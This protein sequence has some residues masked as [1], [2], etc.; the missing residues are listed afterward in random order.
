MIAAL[1]AFALLGGMTSFMGWLADIP[2]L[3]DWYNNGISIQ[4][5]ATVAV[6]ASGIA[7]LCLASGSRRVAA[8]LGLSVAA[9]GAS[10]FLQYLLEVSFDRLNTLLMFG[11]EWGRV[12]V[13]APGRMGP[14]G[15]A[16]W[17]LAGGAV[18]MAS[19]PAAGFRLWAT[20]LALAALSISALS[21]FGYAFDADPLYSLPYLTVIAF[22]TATFV[23]AVSIGV[24][25]AVPEHAPARWLLDDGASGTVARRAIP[26]LAIL[27]FALG[28]I[29]LWGEVAGLYDTR[30]G[31]AIHLFLA[32]SVFAGLLTWM[33]RI[34]TRFETAARQKEDSVSETLASIPDAFF[35]LDHDWRYRYINQEAARLIGKEPR[36]VLGE[37]VWDVIPDATGRT[38][39]HPLRQLAAEGGVVEF[40][41]YNPV[42]RRWFAYR[43][44]RTTDGSIAVYFLDITQRKK[45]ES[46]RAAELAAMTRIQ[47]LS[48]RL[49]PSGDLESLLNEILAAAAELTGTVKGNIQLY[50]PETDSL[51]MVVH[52]GLGP[53]FIERF[54]EQGAPNGCGLAA[55]ERRR[56]LVPDLK[57]EPDWRGSEDLNV[58]LGD[59][60]AAFQSTPLISRGG[61]LLGMLNNHYTEPRSLSDTEVRHLDLLAR[62]AADFIE[63]AHAEESGVLADR[64]KDE[65]LAMLAHELRNP[66]APL[67]NAVQ[68]LR[69]SDGT[70]EKVRST[71]ELLSRQVH[72]L[73]RMVDDLVDVSRI[74]TGRI[75]IVKVSTDLA[76]AVRS[77][78]E[79]A[80]PLI[81]EKQQLLETSLRESAYVAG[82]LTRLAQIVTNLLRNASKFTPAGGHIQVGVVAE[83]SSHVLR[84]RDNG[85]GIAPEHI[86]R[87]FD[88]F[89]QGDVTLERTVSGL[90]VGLALVKTLVQ[91]H[92]GTV[93][94][95]SQGLDHGSEFVVRLPA[96]Q[97]LPTHVVAQ[98]GS[99]SGS[100][101]GRRVLI[102]DDNEDAATS[103]A[104][105]LEIAG[106]I[107]ET[108]HDGH[109]AVTAAELF[110]P[111]VVLLDLGLPKLNGFDVCR[112]I[113]E[114]PWGQLVT[115]VALTGW[116]SDSDRKR[117][118][119]AGFDHHVV[120]PIVYDEL[121]RLMDSKS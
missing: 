76:A 42:S 39:S 18:I 103:L 49:V 29:R 17:I 117:S 94:A 116:G 100:R 31:V 102:V 25:A 114:Q 52:Q 84:V 21:L 64:K 58:L 107:T 2:R 79:A 59:G 36:E 113:R 26:L 91:L 99:E 44:A 63:R 14:P 90:G 112:R 72:Q 62:M 93:E 65:F 20:R 12:G 120:K 43:A 33:L 24:L 111:N 46:E 56:L 55:K 106:H 121:L 22:Q 101:P 10:A 85:I 73:T 108:V 4:P 3:T 1:G 53:A 57:V 97:V 38:A 80:R 41:D 13:T 68:L 87:V 54:R 109:A 15:S 45:A 105:L 95:F 69:Q 32:V 34:I 77:A 104:S 19:Q 27:P 50:D 88:M 74:T 11:R 83:G 51:R 82:D 48:T 30:F 98:N 119:E 60:I 75:N 78:T 66:L 9:I 37:R 92:G 118:R 40:E 89:H 70:A 86:A 23:A 67:Q 47:K 8:V 110:K 115:L 35:V 61:Q 5:N 28:L 6:M 96:L 81:T 16:S 71:T 7:L